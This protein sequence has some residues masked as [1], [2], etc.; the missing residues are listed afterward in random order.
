MLID[1]ATGK[2]CAWSIVSKT[3][4][5][6]LIADGIINKAIFRKQR[7]SYDA[8]LVVGYNHNQAYVTMQ[9][10]SKWAEEPLWVP[11]FI[12]AGKWEQAVSQFHAYENLDRNVEKCLIPEMDD[13]LQ[14]I[15]DT[16]LVGMTR[17]FLI[18]H[19]VLSKPICQRAGKTY[20]FSEN[21]VYSL[22]EASEMFP[23]EKHIKF[24][25]FKPLYETCFNMTVWRKAVSQFTVG[26]TLDECIN[27]FLQTELTHSVRREPSSIDRLVQSIAPPMYE[28][29]PGNDDESTFDYIRITV[30]FPRYQFNSWEALQNEVKKYQPEIYQRVTQRIEKDRQFKK[31]GIPMSFLELSDATL[32]RDFSME[33]IFELK[34]R[35]L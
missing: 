17:D 20:Y 18:E 23:Y 11:S 13:Y 19:G 8:F 15:P 14:S 34:E 7:S 29:V 26:M 3:I 27:I 6:K 32:L 22:D 28:R 30:G 2:G 31:Y 21:K 24:N 33:L 12:D 5:K 35:K 9:T 1:K 16:E 4:T 25:L 10:G